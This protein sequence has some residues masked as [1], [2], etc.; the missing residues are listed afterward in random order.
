MTMAYETLQDIVGTALVDS[1]FRQELLSQPS[2]AV[3]RFELTHE[4]REAIVSIRETT[5]HGFARELQ[6]W[7]N[8]NSAHQR[9][10]L[11][12]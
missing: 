6:G 3:T 1:R 11:P 8:R 2:S 9:A 4:E 5:M 7:I 10:S 12:L